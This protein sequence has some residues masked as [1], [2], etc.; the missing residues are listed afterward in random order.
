MKV[1]K[2]DGLAL[3]QVLLLTTLISVIAIQISKTARSN[4]GIAQGFDDRAQAELLLKSAESNVL[5]ELFR[6][7]SH[8][9][10]GMNINEVNWYLAKA[11]KLNDYTIVEINPLSGRLSL[12]TAPELY[13]KRALLLS[14]VQEDELTATYDSIM[15]W[16]DADNVTR[17]QG[18]E[19]ASYSGNTKPRNGPLQHISELAAIKGV[20]DSVVQKFSQFVTIYATQSFNPAY[21]SKELNTALFGESVAEALVVNSNSGN[22]FTEQDWTKLVGGQTFESIDFN[23][24]TLHQVIIKVSVGTVFLEQVTLVKIQNQNSVTP[25][26]ILSRM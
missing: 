23:P 19:L 13:I 18:A 17:R 1:F 6:M 4:V 11:F 10:N 14:G 3:I 2:E 15:D 21:S 16:I 8:Q 20:S 7:D 22:S 26:V 12:L 24:G 25:F 9:I 5:A